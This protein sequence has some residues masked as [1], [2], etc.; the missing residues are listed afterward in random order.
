MNNTAEQFKKLVTAVQ[1]LSLARS[2]DEVMQVVRLA[3]R[4]LTGADGATFVLRD[5]N[6]CYYAD[7]NAIAPLWKGKRFPMET[8]ISG[9]AMMNK[10]SVAIEDIYQDSRIPQDAYRP[11]FVKS[12][13]MVPIRTKDPVGAI[14]NYW[15]NQHQP[16]SQEIELLQA[17]A[18]SASIA[19]EHVQLIETLEK[20]VHDRTE[21]LEAFTYSV[22]HD[23]EAPLRSI[24]GYTQVL[25]EDHGNELNEDAIQ[26]LSRITRASDR[27]YSLMEG[28]LTLSRLGRFKLEK[29]DVNLSYIASQVTEGLRLDNKEREWE[30]HI[31][32]DVMAYGDQRML[33]VLMEN[34]LRN[35]S[36]FS[37]NQHPSRISFECEETA[38][39]KKIYSVQDN[40]VGFD[41]EFAQRLFQPFQR[42]HNEKEFEGNG[43]G[44]ATVYKI[45]TRHGGEIWAQSAPG[46]GAKFFFT[47]P[48]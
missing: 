28:L 30:I 6:L 2:L 14:G 9:W 25:K 36:K 3:A 48:H 21:E 8:C 27:M 10:H 35:A 44:L 22:S 7:E 12:L 32:P 13:A 38:L 33:Q 5:G 45:V 26:C 41:M 40:G 24:K 47:I 29:R 42:F 16:T 37:R 11:T 31:Q 4:D 19:I 1:D 46:K 18:D 17:L 20:K 39:G 15:A 23:L 43:I 34:L